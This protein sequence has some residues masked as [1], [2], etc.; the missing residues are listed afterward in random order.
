ML[1]CLQQEKYNGRVYMFE[2]YTDRAR[3]VIGY[4][5]RG[6]ADTGYASVEPRHLLLGVIRLERDWVQGLLNNQHSVQELEREV[7]GWIPPVERVPSKE[8]VLSEECRSILHKAGDLAS[9]FGHPLI[10]SED[11]FLAILVLDGCSAANSALSFGVSITAVHQ[12]VAA[13]R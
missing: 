5:V 3:R 8:A 12:E 6:A 4:A 11:I 13:L 7:R 10:R 1:G 2:R 9:E